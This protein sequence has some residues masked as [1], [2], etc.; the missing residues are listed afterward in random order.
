MRVA[1]P[2]HRIHQNAAVSLYDPHS[3]AAVLLPQR[4]GRRIVIFCNRFSVTLMALAFLAAIVAN[5]RAEAQVKPFK[6]KGGG[7][8]AFFPPIGEAAPHTIEGQATH[9]GQHPG[10]G[11][12]QPMMRTHGCCQATSRQPNLT[13]WNQRSS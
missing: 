5:N 6:I 13:I 8:L 3:D 12:V 2:Q 11:W 1:L 4:I 7:V 9:L 10:L